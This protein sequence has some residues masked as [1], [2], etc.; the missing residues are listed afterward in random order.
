MFLATG[1]AQ[2]SPDE[3]PDAGTPVR[4]DPSAKAGKFSELY[5]V[6]QSAK[7]INCHGMAKRN[8]NFDLHVA[9]HRFPESTDPA[10]DLMSCQRCHTKEKGFANNWHAPPAEMD[11]S[12]KTVADTCN[13]LKT[14]GF[15]MDPLRDHLKSDAIVLWALARLDVKVKDWPEKVDAWIDGGMKC[16]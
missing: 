15:G 14:S 7:C 5:P 10:A 4:A 11:F 9:R 3:G 2:M 12:G 6:L 8:K 1:H 13:Q 16:P